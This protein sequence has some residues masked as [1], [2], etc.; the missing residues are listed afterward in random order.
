MDDYEKHIIKP[1]LSGKKSAMKGYDD[2]KPVSLLSESL[3]GYIDDLKKL[4]FEAQEKLRKEQMDAQASSDSTKI[5]DV[6]EEA[7]II[8]DVQEVLADDGVGAEDNTNEQEKK[9]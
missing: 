9:D 7:E 2:S 6:D 3:K 8:E 5:E 1:I 4:Q